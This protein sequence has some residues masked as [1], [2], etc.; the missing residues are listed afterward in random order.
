[1]GLSA[2]SAKGGQDVVVFRI[3][4]SGCGMNEEVRRKATQPFFSA[5]PAGRKRGMGLAYASRFIQIN[6]GSLVIESQP[7][8][9]T[10]VTVSMPAR[11]R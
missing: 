8:R 1:M 4:D 3:Q 2:E 10:T 5:K 9:G 6:G 11:S 7:Q